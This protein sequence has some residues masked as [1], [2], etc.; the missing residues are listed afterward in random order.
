MPK[1]GSYFLTAPYDVGEAEGRPYFALEFVAGGSLA[2]HLDGTPQ[3]A[4]PAA[5]LLETLARAVQAA[6]ANGVVHRDLKPA[7]ILLQKQGGTM[8]EEQP[9]PSG[10][11]LHPSS[12]ILPKIADFGIAK[13]V[14]GAGEVPSRSGPTVTGEILGTPSYMAPEQAATPASRWARPQMCMPWGRSFMKS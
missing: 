4:R 10:L 11:I 6:H 7:N 9:N 12:F 2:R 14:D 3:P 13:C 5:Q 8:Q 1:W